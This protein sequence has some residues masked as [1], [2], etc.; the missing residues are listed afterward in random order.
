MFLNPEE[1]EHRRCCGCIPC[2][3]CREHKS[4]NLDEFTT[5]MFALGYFDQNNQQNLL[6]LRE[7]FHKADKDDNGIIDIDEFLV[8]VKETSF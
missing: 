6:T 3:R 1:V 5:A 2:C 8:Y 7:Y 4:S